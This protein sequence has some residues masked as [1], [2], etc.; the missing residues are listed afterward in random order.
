MKQFYFARQSSVNQHNG[1]I[2]LV[3]SLY[4]TA[5]LDEIIK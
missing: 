3:S 5:C 2:I 1:A 4:Q